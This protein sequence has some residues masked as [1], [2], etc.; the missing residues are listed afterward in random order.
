MKSGR[1]QTDPRQS[2]KTVIEMLEEETGRQVEFKQT[3]NYNGVIEGLKSGTVDVGMLGPFSYVLA[4]TVGAKLTPVM[5][6]AHDLSVQSVRS[7]KCDV[8]F[9]SDTMVDTT[10]PS[11]GNL[12]AGEIKVVWR[13]P[14]I[15]SSPVAMRNALPEDVRKKISETFLTKLNKDWLVENGKCAD[16]KSCVVAG[17]AGMG[18]YV[19]AQDKTFDPVRKVCATTQDEQC[20]ATS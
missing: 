5:A 2:W 6:G 8:G 10:M 16:A 15:P 9:A 20:E 7:G 12:R 11:T 13:S 18:G 1:Q 4:R 3:T 14:A 17:K 19:A